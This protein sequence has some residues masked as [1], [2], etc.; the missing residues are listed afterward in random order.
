MKRGSCVLSF[1]CRIGEM[2]R[3]QIGFDEQE[4]ALA[5]KQTKALG[6]SLAEFVRQATRNALSQSTKARWMRSLSLRELCV[7]VVRH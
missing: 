5:K 4:Y 7:Q 1:V 2:I 6:V 3:T